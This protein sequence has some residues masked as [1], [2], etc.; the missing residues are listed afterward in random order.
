[1]LSFYVRVSSGRFDAI[2]VLSKADLTGRQSFQNKS[3]TDREHVLTYTLLAHIGT[4][5]AEMN[6]KEIHFQASSSEE[7]IVVIEKLDPF[8]F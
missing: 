7:T 5:R 6:K 3:S 2:V 4:H 1:M 8:F